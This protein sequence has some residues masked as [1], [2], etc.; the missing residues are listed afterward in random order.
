MIRELFSVTSFTTSPDVTKD[1]GVLFMMSPDVTKDMEHISMTS[2]DVT[3][4]ER[5]NYT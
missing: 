3:S 5:V 4:S 2:V 1:P